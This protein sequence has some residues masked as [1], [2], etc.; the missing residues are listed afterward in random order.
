MS[1]QDHID[2]LKE[3]KAYYLD[4]VDHIDKTLK[5]FDTMDEHPKIFP[6][7]YYLGDTLKCIL[8]K[9][10]KPAAGFT[11][12][13]FYKIK[14]IHLDGRGAQYVIVLWD[15]NNNDRTFAVPNLR[16]K[17]GKINTHKPKL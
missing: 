16:K 13:K 3:K 6:C 11:I 7:P 10:I 2:F 4:L 12:G 17:F 14:G 15:D 8:P 1:N 9:K 5:I